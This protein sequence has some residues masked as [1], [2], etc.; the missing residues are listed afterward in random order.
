[1]RL[2]KPFESKPHE[3]DEGEDPEQ[4]QWGELGSLSRTLYPLRLQHSAK[5]TNEW[6]QIFCYRR[7]HDLWNRFADDTTV[8]LLASLRLNFTPW[9]L[10]IIFS[11]RNFGLNFIAEDVEFL[12]MKR[13]DNLLPRPAFTFRLWCTDYGPCFTRLSSQKCCPTRY[14]QLMPEIWWCDDELLRWMMWKS[15]GVGLVMILWGVEETVEVEEIEVECVVYVCWSS[16]MLRGRHRY[17]PFTV[18]GTLAER[19]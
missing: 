19:K 1:V 2:N 10:I 6:V 7:P 17:S 14:V 3:I 15:W 12:I 9:L 18:R 11:G 13:G 5:S 16:V 8:Q 4:R